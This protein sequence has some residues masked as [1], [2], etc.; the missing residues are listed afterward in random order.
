[1]RIQNAEWRIVLDDIIGRKSFDFAKRILDLYKYL[2]KEKKEYILSNQIFR[3]GTSIG[4]NVVEAEDGESRADFRHKMH[5]ALKE[6]SE[7]IYWLKLLQYGQYI[8]E[9]QF[10][11]LYKDANELKSILVAIVKGTK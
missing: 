2:I 5:I 7:T 10:E 11:S 6:V 8:T 4:A 9:K 3:S 1:M